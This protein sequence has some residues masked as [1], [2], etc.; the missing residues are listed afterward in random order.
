MPRPGWRAFQP[1]F[2]S[3]TF[4]E[5]RNGPLAPPQEM[6]RFR[7]GLKVSFRVF[8]GSTPRLPA[9]FVHD[10]AQNGNA[11]ILAERPK[12]ELR[13]CIGGVGVDV[14]RRLAI[15]S[16]L[17]RQAIEKLALIQ[18]VREAEDLQR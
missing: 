11:P 18:L 5:S 13:A 7:S 1:P 3:V 2:K 12:G 14:F 15:R 8:A 17:L 16:Q 6:A 10:F 4:G 9:D